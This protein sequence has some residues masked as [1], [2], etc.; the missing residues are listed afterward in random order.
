MLACLSEMA[1]GIGIGSLSV[2][3]R[4]EVRQE[5][6]DLFFHGTIGCSAGMQGALQF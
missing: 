3:C 2:V 4:A 5:L 6:R 1:C